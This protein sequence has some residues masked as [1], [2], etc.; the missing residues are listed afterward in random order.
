MALGRNLEHLLHSIP[1]WEFA[2]SPSVSLN[3]DSDIEGFSTE[4]ST[5]REDNE[6]Y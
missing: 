2:S 5:E 6:P 4:C 1:L 3:G